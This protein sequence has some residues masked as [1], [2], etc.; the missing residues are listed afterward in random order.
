MRYVLGR[1]GDA[2]TMNRLQMDCVSPV[3]ILGGR[4]GGGRQSME[5]AEGA[6]P[7]SSQEKTETTDLSVMVKG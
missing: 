2:R 5:R 6:R 1:G 7:E 4:G 3:I